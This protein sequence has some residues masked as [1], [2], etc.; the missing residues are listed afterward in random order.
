M[1]AV[2]WFYIGG[3]DEI[4]QMG[5][6]KYRAPMVLIRGCVEDGKLYF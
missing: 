5:T 6:W 1:D 4:G 2:L 3:M